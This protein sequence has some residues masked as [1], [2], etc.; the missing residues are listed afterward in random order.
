M[1]GYFYKTSK[2][3]VFGKGTQ[4]EHSVDTFLTYVS[5]TKTLTLAQEECDKLNSE[6][7]DKL[8]NGEPAKCDERIYFPREMD[9]DYFKD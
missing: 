9:D 2:P 5:Y 4:Y 3:M 6:K 8:W 1:I 7:P